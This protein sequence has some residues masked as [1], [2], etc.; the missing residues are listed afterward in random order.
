M[1]AT[2]LG[3][4]H[5]LSWAR[6]GI[7]ASVSNL[8]NGSLPDRAALNVQLS[9][10]V[11][12]G[13]VTNTVQPNA[14]NVQLFGPGD[15]IGID[16]RHIIRTEPRDFTVNFEPN[17]LCGIEFDAPDF[18]WLFTPAAPKGDRLRP[19][20]ALIALKPDEFQLPSVAPNPLPVVEVQKI[21]ALQDLSESWNW[22][23]VKISGDLSLADTLA[24]SPGNVL[25]RLLCP[26]R[27]DPETSYT[28][29]L[30][31]AFEIGRKAGLGQDVSSIHSADPAWTKQTAPPLQLPFYYQ[32]Q[33]HTS[34]AGDFESLVRRLTPRVLT[35]GVGQRP[36]DV[37]QPAHHIPTAGGPLGLEGALHSVSTQPTAWDVADKTAFQSAVQ[38]WINQPAA[39]ADDPKNPNPDDPVIAPPIYGRWHAAVQAVDRTEAGWVNDLNLDPRNR[40]GAGMGTQVV[41]E[42][43]TQLMASAWQQVDGVRKANQLLKQAQLARAALQ[44]LYRQHFQPALP[45]TV[46]NLTAPVHAR[47]LASPKTIHAVVGASLLPQRALSGAFRR[48]TRPRRRLGAPAK[49]P[50]LLTRINTG[51]VTVVPPFRAPDGLVSIEQVSDRLGGTDDLRIASF[52]PQTVALLPSRP[53]FTV[54]PPGRATEP[55]GAKRLGQG[56]LSTS[57]GITTASFS[58]SS[59]T[60]GSH[61]ITAIYR[62]DANF[63]GS[64][65]TLVQTVRKAST[66]T[67]VVS[68]VNPSAPGQSVTFTASIGAVTPGAGTPT[69]TVQFQIDWSNAGRPVSIGS[70]SSGTTATF[71]VTGL[72]AGT[73][74]VTAT[75]SGDGCFAGSTGTLSGGQT[76]NKASTTTALVSAPNPST[77]GQSVTFT[78]TVSGLGTPTGVVNFLD[79]PTTIIGRGELRGALGGGATASFSTSSLGIGSHTISAVYAGDS[80]F[81]GSSGVL[82]QTVGEANTTTVV[83]SSANPSAPGQSVTFK[84]TVSGPGT[85]TGTVTFSDGTT[86]L[87]RATLSGAASGVATASFSS[88]SLTVGSH[89]ITAAYGGDAN[90]AGST[91][92]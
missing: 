86:V 78:A 75:Y 15:V 11:Q 41:Q 13:G 28:A 65:G 10:A 91:G 55:G 5:F 4:Y 9:L 53:N 79:G 7:G 67:V 39:A 63:P 76:V 90:F 73:H 54:A 44:Q 38:A 20:I 17:Y 64:T 40:A 6:R 68:S 3:R 56:T 81:L 60:V 50:A 87:G 35:D 51:E 59:L 32:F 72:S 25:S 21:T 2:T 57:G 84:A 70:T 71:S 62:G 26:R 1:S 24:S 82:I 14:M 49:R 36:M 42:E 83:S 77:L 48:V 43:R 85:P 74:G 31:P 61:P 18:P 58:T 37:S 19:W 46:M 29:F 88:S 16:P 33:F 23:H 92:R 34:D 69:G 66:N 47:L 30:V 22:G 12:Q 80:N 45:E 89:T 52:R 27:L 8:D